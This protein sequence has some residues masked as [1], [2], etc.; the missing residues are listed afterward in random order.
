MTFD[1]NENVLGTVKIFETW[2]RNRSEIS[3]WSDSLDLDNQEHLKLFAKYQIFV[4]R[5]FKI[6]LKLKK[7]DR[8]KVL[9]AKGSEKLA[10]RWLIWSNTCFRYDFLP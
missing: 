4:I 1:Y 6:I 7:K 2:S 5:A 9:N 10:T 3:S 8:S